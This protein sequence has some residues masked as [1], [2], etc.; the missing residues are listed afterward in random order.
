MYVLAHA[1]AYVRSF[2]RYIL[3]LH[4]VV[5]FLNV[6]RLGAMYTKC[7]LKLCFSHC[8]FPISAHIRSAEYIIIAGLITIFITI[9]LALYILFIIYLL[10]IF[11]YVSML[12]KNI[13]IIRFLCIFFA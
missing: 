8:I 9:S 11:C 1:Q 3:S 12:L 4:G 5:H 7:R 2:K 10:L 6:Y 13:L